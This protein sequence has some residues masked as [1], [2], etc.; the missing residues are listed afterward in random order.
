MKIIKRWYNNYKYKK[1][2]LDSTKIY[3]CD[4]AAIASIDNCDRCN[5]QLSVGDLYDTKII[6]KGSV[7]TDTERGYGLHLKLC[8]GCVQNIIKKKTNGTF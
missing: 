5:K 7:L 8:K 2:T 6:S 3:I 1:F 4:Y